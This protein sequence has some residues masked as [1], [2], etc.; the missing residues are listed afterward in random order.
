MGVQLG[1]GCLQSLIVRDPLRGRARKITA[2]ATSKF[3][4]TVLLNYLVPLIKCKI[5][6]IFYR[7]IGSIGEFHIW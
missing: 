4:S 7:G 5:L 3:P 6:D 2:C 1:R